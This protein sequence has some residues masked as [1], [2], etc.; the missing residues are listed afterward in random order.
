MRIE[1]VTIADL[2]LF[3]F[4]REQAA[5]RDRA[6]LRAWVRAGLV[7]RAWYLV[8]L[9]V[10]GIGSPLGFLLAITVIGI[11][12]TRVGVRLVRALVHLARTR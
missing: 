12:L 11:A 2:Q 1:R 9:A 6:A 8:P 10:I 7:R 4:D 5:A 3:E